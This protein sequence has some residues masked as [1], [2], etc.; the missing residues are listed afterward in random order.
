MNTVQPLG[1]CASLYH[2][3]ITSSDSTWGLEVVVVLVVEVEVVNDVV[4]EVENVLHLS[5]VEQQDDLVETLEEVLVVVA[6]LLHLK[7]ELRKQ[8]NTIGQ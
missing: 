8:S 7:A 4:V 2:F 6:I 1:A 5:L 3:R